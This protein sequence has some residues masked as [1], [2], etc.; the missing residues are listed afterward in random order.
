MYQAL[1]TLGV[2]SELIV[3]PDQ[4]HVLTRPSF[5]VDRSRRYLDWMARYLGT[6]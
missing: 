2:P 6:R 1:R 3:Y 5:L 4:Y